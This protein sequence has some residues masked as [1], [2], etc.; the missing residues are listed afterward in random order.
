MGHRGYVASGL[1]S[2]LARRHEVIGWGRE[3]DVNR[4]DGAILSELRIDAVL[5]CAVAYER[6]IE[7]VAEGSLSYRVNIAGARAIVK[8]LDGSST[9][10]IQISTK[11]IF[12][13]VYSTA[14]LVP[15]ESRDEPTFLVDE[16]RAPAPRTAYGKSKL[17]AEQI[18]LSYAWSTV[19]RLSTIYSDLD[20]PRGGWILRFAKQAALGEA[21]RIE[22]S[23]RQVRD[24]L[25]TADLANLIERILAAK[26]REVGRQTL[27][28]GG[29][30]A[31]LVS[32]E[33]VARL[34]DPNVKVEHVPGVDTGFA[35]DIQRAQEL[36]GWE[37]RI[38]L[39][40][41]IGLVRVA[42]QSVKRDALL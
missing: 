26:Q 30:M 23:G 5:N 13:P 37:P 3:D 4:L 25:H 35:F 38:R 14:D 2:E 11:D 16:S 31:N 21:I 8:A 10:F 17:V 7:S 20:H 39:T 42:A 12:G 36:L 32:V 18:A 34:I 27:H 24:P 29:G 1:R 19:V 28:A 41:R 15:R 6:G 22:G 33:E 40:E 9:R